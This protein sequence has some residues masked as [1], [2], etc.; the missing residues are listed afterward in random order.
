MCGLCRNYM[1]S[2]CPRCNK[3]SYGSHMRIMPCMHCHDLVLAHD[4][5]VFVP[6]NSGQC[7]RGGQTTGIFAAFECT[8]GSGESVWL[9]PSPSTRQAL[10]PPKGIRSNPF[11]RER[12]GRECVPPSDSEVWS[13]TNDYI[14]TAWAKG[15]ADPMERVDLIDKVFRALKGFDVKDESLHSYVEEQSTHIP[16]FQACKEMF[17][18]HKVVTDGF[19]DKLKAQY[20]ASGSGETFESWLNSERE[21]AATAA[22]L[23]YEKRRK[24]GQPVDKLR[25]KAVLA[26]KCHFCGE[27]AT[28][29]KALKTCSR[30]KDAYY[31]D[32][33]C[34]RKDW[35]NHKS[36]CRRTA[37]A[38]KRG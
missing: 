27:K 23:E 11:S 12:D 36:V 30:C 18:H 29:Y 5:I 32:A 15:E 8:C 1:Y 35:P 13:M 2:H 14:E 24:V 4:G 34:Q 38:E 10:V 17:R 20:T 25:Y 31:C 16:Q 7:L 21:H 22:K 3:C 37:D 6:R 28:A 26:D 9:D 33:A 19:L